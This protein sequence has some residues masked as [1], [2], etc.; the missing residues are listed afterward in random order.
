MESLLCELINATLCG[1][2]VDEERV[3][4]V[5]DEEWMRCFELAQRQ[6]V[7]AMTF[8]TMMSLPDGLRPDFMVWSKWMSRAKATADKVYRNR[9]AARKVGAW[10]AEESL[11]T[12]VIKGLSLAVLY[13]RPELRPS[14]DVDIYSGSDYEAVNACL[15][16]HGAW[17]SPADGHHC[18]VIVDGI[19]V[20]NHFAFHNERVRHGLNELDGGVL[21]RLADSDRRA[22][23][24]PGIYFPN[25]VFVAL[26]TAWHACHHFLEEKIEL[27]H[28]V[29]WALS[30]KRLTADEVAALHEA[31]GDARWGRF[32]DTLTA[33]ALHRLHL[34][35]EWFPRC[36]LEAAA[37]I[38]GELERRTWDDIIDSRPTPQGS[39][40]MRRRFMQVSRFMKNSWKYK[41]YANMGAAQW[42]WEVFGGYVR[43]RLEK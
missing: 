4:G 10:L 18:L 35:E 36:E 14:S 42:V 28:V 12:M 6:R 41:E 29:D 7:D 8:P 17:Q 40:P 27:R 2:P 20:E 39:S 13:P 31:K 43:S 34:P 9:S 32:A 3:R 19:Y 11:Q 25:P 5:T 23:P 22:T 21:Q 30:L 16:R 37:A 1:R 24:L 15:V 38:S 33:I 26:H